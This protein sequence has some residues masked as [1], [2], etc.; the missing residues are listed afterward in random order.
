MNTTYKPSNIDYGE[1]LSHRYSFN[2]QAVSMGTE[3][4]WKRSMYEDIDI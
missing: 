2:V 3:K 1:Y 4:E